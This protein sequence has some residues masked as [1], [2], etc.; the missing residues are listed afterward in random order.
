MAEPGAAAD[1][2]HLKHLDHVLTVSLLCHIAQLSSDVNAP[3]DVHVHLHGLLLD[4]GVQLCDVLNP[5]HHRKETK[6]EH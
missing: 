4:L 1:A 2:S 6:E 3:A 5:Q